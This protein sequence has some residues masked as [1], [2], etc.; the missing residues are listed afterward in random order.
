MNKIPA[1]GLRE[2]KPR[3]VPLHYRFDGPRQGSSPGKGHPICA[4]ALRDRGA[5]LIRL[6]LSRLGSSE[7]AATAPPN[8][9]KASVVNK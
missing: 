4:G 1:E 2:G 8:T 7:R 9:Y 3:P 6:D 5:R